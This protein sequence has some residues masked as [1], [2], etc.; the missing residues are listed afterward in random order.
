MR[1]RPTPPRLEFDAGLRKELKAFPAATGEAL[2][3]W[4]TEGLVPA[5]KATSTRASE[6]P[7][8]PGLL[9]K[10]VGQKPAEPV[11]PLLA[12]KL[13][14]R[15][16]LE[17]EEDWPMLGPR[18]LSFLGQV[19][20]AEL[21]EHVPDVP[22]RGLLGFFVNTAWPAKQVVTCRWYPAPDASRAAL[23]PLVVP[24]VA[25]YEARLRFAPAWSP[26]WSDGWKARV[27]GAADALW[28]AV[29]EW[30][31]ELG[32]KLGDS[33][34]AHVLFGN[35]TAALL[36]EAGPGV[37][38]DQLIARFTCDSAADFAWGTN[39]LYVLTRREDFEA[40]RFDRT[41]SHVAN[42]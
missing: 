3:A 1:A 24:A 31:S 40:G 16:Y 22:R 14:G 5:Y 13:G 15:P 21:P 29:V 30:S 12:S 10:L 38:A 37:E 33:E 39:W 6:R 9:G 28:D 20:F 17:S 27:G 23:V 19:N 8:V 7:Q 2:R 34:N 32:E 35:A 25:R 42:G 11:L 18:R 26:P 4:F 36:E 41:E